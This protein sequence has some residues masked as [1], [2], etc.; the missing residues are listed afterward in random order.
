[1]LLASAECHQLLRAWNDTAAP[2]AGDGDLFGRL[3]AVAA[4]WP[5][6]IAVRCGDGTL[7]FGERAARARGL[8]ER[9]RRRGVGADVPVVLLAERSLELVLALCGVWAAGGA[10]VPVSPAYPERRRRE[11]LDDTAAPLLLADAALAADPGGGTP[12]AAL[13]GELLAPLRE[14]APRPA[15]PAEA[16]AYVL[17]TSGSTGKPKGVAVPRGAVLHLLAALEATVYRGEAAGAPLVVS[18]Q[19]PVVFDASVKQLVQL[20]AGRTLEV[21]PEELRLDPRGLVR[22]LAERQVDVLDAT[23]AQV[24][25]L[26]EAGLGEEGGPRRALIGGEAIG[27]PLWQ[28][29]A[30]HPRIRFWNVYGPTETTVDAT[31]E[32]IGTATGPTLGGPLPNVTAHLVDRAG[33]PLPVG[34]VGELLLGGRG[35]ARGYR[36]RPAA[37]AERFR[38]DPWGPPGARL[39]ATGDLARRRGDG[40]LLYLGR[41]DHQVKV[42][43]FRIELGEIESAL[44]AAPGVRAAAVLAVGPPGDLRLVAFAAP[45]AGAEPAPDELAA[46]LEERL[47]RQCRPQAVRVLPELPLTPHGKVDRA[48]LRA[49]VEALLAAPRPRRAPATAVEERLVAIWAEL[50]GLAPEQ[51]S[52]DDNFFDLGGHSLHLARLLSRVREGLGVEMGLAALFTAPTVTA[53]AEA[54]E[55]AR[56]AR[57][58]EAPAE[59]EAELE[60]IEL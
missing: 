25:L 19:A 3:E 48:A 46:F 10:Y 38:P 59:A 55:L 16:L 32:P 21:V 28:R 20:L 22:F 43:G 17:Y 36:G 39:Y 53:M 58:G 34:M 35:V 2:A 29:L 4:R 5:G 14:P 41:R 13:A 7:S 40:R 37:T 47:P 45:A 51:V 27:A 15:A 33:R 54:V 23:P 1:L 31:V 50:L 24:E 8:G 6:R 26:L 18:V 12:A 56:W 52:T 44:A 57:G 9:L 42:R 30:A 49:H 11:T 60:E